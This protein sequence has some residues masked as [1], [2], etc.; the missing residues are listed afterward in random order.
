M[1][2]YPY[3]SERDI[4]VLI[5]SENKNKDDM[6]ELLLRICCQN[7]TIEES[8]F[9]G[10]FIVHIESGEVYIDEIQM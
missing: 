3:L 2:V 6:I 9:Y 8:W 10:E 5:L 4:V 7:V 1:L